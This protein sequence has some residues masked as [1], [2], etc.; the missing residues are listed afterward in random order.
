VI[1]LITATT[2]NTGLNVFARLDDTIYPQKLK[3][4]DE[5]IAAVNITGHH[6][7]PEWNYT[8]SPSLIDS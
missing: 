8:I 2:T 4:T 5:Q 1:E 6:F 7:H 3:I